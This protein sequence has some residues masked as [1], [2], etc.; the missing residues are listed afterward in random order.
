MLRQAL[1]RAREL[2]MAVW[3]DESKNTFFEGRGRCAPAARETVKDC[4]LP[5]ELFHDD[6]GWR[7]AH[8]LLFKADRQS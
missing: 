8:L 1:E 2:E 5:W 7:G 3:F 6:L 4:P